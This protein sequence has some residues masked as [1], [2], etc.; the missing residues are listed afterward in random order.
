MRNT[1][2]VAERYLPVL[3]EVVFFDAASEYIGIL[4]GRVN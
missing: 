3:E 2:G 4:L 1:V